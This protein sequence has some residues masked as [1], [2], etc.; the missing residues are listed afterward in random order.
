MWVESVE[1][2]KPYRA[3]N[4]SHWGCQVAC[5]CKEEDCRIGMEVMA[6]ADRFS[7]VTAFKRQRELI[8]DGNG[9]SFI[10]ISIS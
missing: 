3:E 10:R 6:K 9:G 8:K 1:A 2:E 7:K 4:S 5:Q